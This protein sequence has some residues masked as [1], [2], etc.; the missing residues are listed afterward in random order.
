[1]KKL[2]SKATNKGLRKLRRNGEAP[3]ASEQMG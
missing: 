1:M 3:G 2:F